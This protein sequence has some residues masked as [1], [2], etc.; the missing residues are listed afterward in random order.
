[1]YESCLKSTCACWSLLLSGSEYMCTCVR[2]C[3]VVFLRELAYMHVCF[4]VWRSRY[5][6]NNLF[7]HICSSMSLYILMLHLLEITYLNQYMYVY[8]YMYLQMRARMYLL[9]P[10]YKYN[11][12]QD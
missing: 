2:I 8:R 1:M 3:V 6:Q 4:G 7:Q 11:N 9:V 10:T 12:F 5:I